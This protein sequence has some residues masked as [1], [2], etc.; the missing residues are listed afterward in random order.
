VLY[1]EITFD[2]ST[3]QFCESLWWYAKFFYFY[4]DVK[5]GYKTCELGVYSKFVNGGDYTCEK[6]YYTMRGL[7]DKNFVAPAY[8]NLGINTCNLKKAGWFK[9][10]SIKGPKA[11]TPAPV[12]IIEEVEEEEVS[13]TVVVDKETSK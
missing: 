2:A 13:E 4:L 7:I 12:V 8:G 1:N 3:L 9:M 5:I 10:S 6:T 11:P